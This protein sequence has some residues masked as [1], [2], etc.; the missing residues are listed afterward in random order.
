MSDPMGP[1]GNGG[2]ADASSPEVLAQLRRLIDIG[3]TAS[4]S[5]T[6]DEVLVALGSPEPT[7]EF[8]AAITE[9]LGGQGIAV[10]P[11]EPVEDLHA[12]PA[13]AA[14]AEAPAPAPKAPPPTPAAAPR[15]PRKRAPA[16]DR[17]GGRGAGA[18]AQGA[19]AG[20]GPP[21]AAEAGPGSG[22]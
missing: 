9:L 3:R 10:D 13:E 17:D 15:A 21:C 11:E 19:A 2:P 8:I 7:P 12:V 1:A 16:A 18:D 22:P 4:G 20:T 14:V 6:V 5:V